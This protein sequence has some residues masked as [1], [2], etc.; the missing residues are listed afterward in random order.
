MRVYY[1]SLFNLHIYMINLIMQ[2]FNDYFS[3][4]LYKMCLKQGVTKR[5]M[6]FEK[7]L[8]LCIYI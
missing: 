5:E 1:Y 7:S 8:N 4:E 6:L 3:Y 2:N